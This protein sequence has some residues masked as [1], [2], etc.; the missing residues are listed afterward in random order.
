[1]GF[2]FSAFG[3]LRAMPSVNETRLARPG[4]K[5]GLPSAPERVTGGGLTGLARPPRL[6]R[7]L[8]V[9]L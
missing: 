1:M 3:A 8:L 4:A 9:W 6:V 7:V 5:A 2:T